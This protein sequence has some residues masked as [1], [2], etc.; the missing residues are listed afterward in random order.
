MG[1]LKVF[2]D[3]VEE[4][5]SSGNQGNVWSYAEIDLSSYT[6]SVV[7]EFVYL[8]S[9]SWQGDCAISNITIEGAP[10]STVAGIT[11][12]EASGATEI[13]DANTGINVTATGGGSYSWSGGLGGFCQIKT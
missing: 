2:V 8:G 7:I 3:G 13:T 4:F 11:N 6:G 1:T 12:N 9:G 5:T 10:C